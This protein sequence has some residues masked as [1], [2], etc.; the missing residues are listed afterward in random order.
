MWSLWFGF[1]DLLN[2]GNIHFWSCSLMILVLH[3]HRGSEKNGMFCV[4]M[5]FGTC[6]QKF[7]SHNPYAVGE[8]HL[9]LC[10]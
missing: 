10:S 5:G 9:Y 6:L 1:T 4:D 7:Q 8:S 3:R 2:P